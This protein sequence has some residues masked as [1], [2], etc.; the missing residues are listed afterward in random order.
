MNWAEN[1]K[2]TSFPTT[3]TRSTCFRYSYFSLLGELEVEGPSPTSEDMMPKC[4][5]DQLSKRT[6]T[7]DRHRMNVQCARRLFAP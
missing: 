4:S 1:N 7:S 2:D 5:R 6:T 3:H